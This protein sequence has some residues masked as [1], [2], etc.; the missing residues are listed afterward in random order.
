M[1]V[2]AATGSGSSHEVVAKPEG[3]TANEARMWAPPG[4]RVTKERRWHN[5]WRIEAEVLGGIR[6]KS[7]GEATGLTDYEAMAWVLRLA[8]SAHTRQT[9]EQCPWVFRDARLF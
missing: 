8:W 6:S 3:Y 2:A 7:W 9:G 1:S 4:S 5:R